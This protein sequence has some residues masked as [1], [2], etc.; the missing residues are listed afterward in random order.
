MNFK[1]KHLKVNFELLSMI[2]YRY[3]LSIYTEL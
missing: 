3:D 2:Y 1:Q